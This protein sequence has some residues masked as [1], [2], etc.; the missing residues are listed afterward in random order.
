VLSVDTALHTLLEQAQAADCLAAETVA[1]ADA[2]N[3]LVTALWLT[4]LMVMRPSAA[5]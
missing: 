5:C 4:L 3:R 2:E 1:F